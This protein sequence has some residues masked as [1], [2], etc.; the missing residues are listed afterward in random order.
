MWTEGAG[1]RDAH[2]RLRLHVGALRQQR[3]N[4]LQVAGNRGGEERRLSVLRRRRA[5]RS[6]PAS[7]ILPRPSRLPA[8]AHAAR[9]AQV[10]PLPPSFHPPPTRPIAFREHVH[11]IHRVPSPSPLPPPP[12]W[13]I[14]LKFL[15][16][17]P[18]INQYTCISI[19]LLIY[20]FF[21]SFCIY[22]YTYPRN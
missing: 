22:T 17:H 6:A 5:S 2:I 20:P 7:A 12:L 16:I 8:P 21:P 19:I 1:A 18:Y 4:H 3:P 14:I 13:Y 10:R 15:S 9:R 11:S